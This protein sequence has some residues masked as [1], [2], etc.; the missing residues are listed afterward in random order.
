MQRTLTPKQ[1]RVLEAIRLYAKMKGYMPSIR[2]VAKLTKTAV[3]T[4][5]DHILTLKVKGWIHTDGTSRGIRLVEDSVS[6]IDMVAVPVVGSILAG[7]PIKAIEIR[8]EPISLSRKAAIPGSFALRVKGDSMIEDHILD[9]D[10]VIVSPQTSV[11]N[12]EIAV[13]LLQDGTAT[14]KRVFREK[15]RIRLQPANKTTT[16]IFVSKISIQG[17][18]TAVLRLHRQ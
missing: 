6:A 5:H 7:Q 17:K 11:P 18:V 1:K 9:G 10:V 13:A 14:L 4:V 15:R 16:P 3:G 12:G 2:D 8:E